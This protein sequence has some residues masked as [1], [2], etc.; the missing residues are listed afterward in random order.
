MSAILSLRLI[1]AAL[2]I[3]AAARIPSPETD[4]ADAGT[5][6]RASPLALLSSCTS[7]TVRSCFLPLALLPLHSSACHTNFERSE[8]PDI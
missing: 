6:S 7:L 5:T 3:L 2:R 1:D 8:T 4:D